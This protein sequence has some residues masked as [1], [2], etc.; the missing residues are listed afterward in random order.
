ME[1]KITNF[2]ICKSTET[3]HFH[4]QQKVSSW[5]NWQLMNFA[6]DDGQNLS[7]PP[8][9]NCKTVLRTKFASSSADK[10][11]ARM[12]FSRSFLHRVYCLHYC[13]TKFGKGRGCV[14]SYVYRAQKTHFLTTQ[15][16][17]NISSTHDTIIERETD[18][19]TMEQP[20]DMYMLSE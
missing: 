17:I 7:A 11:Y 15:D 19:T 9:S 10:T 4:D 12:C 3:H 6:T 13:H 1:S 18:E 14:I 20:D 16:I 5:I 8:K 2:A